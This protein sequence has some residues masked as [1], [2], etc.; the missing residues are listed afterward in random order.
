MY[1]WR[2]PVNRANIKNVKQKASKSRVVL[3]KTFK[4]VNDELDNSLSPKR[5]SY[6]LTKV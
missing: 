3:L 4:H 5:F 2:I 1:E 6:F